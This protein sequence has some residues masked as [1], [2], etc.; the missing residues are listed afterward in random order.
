MNINKLLTHNT[1]LKQ[2]QDHSQFTPEEMQQIK[3]YT[4]VMKRM[5][6]S[7]RVMI[8]ESKLQR[9]ESRKVLEHAKKCKFGICTCSECLGILTNIASEINAFFQTIIKEVNYGNITKLCWK[10][11]KAVKYFKS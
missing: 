5:N 6:A 1:I 3:R 11:W 7:M 9:E 4:E 10:G 8:L 2:D